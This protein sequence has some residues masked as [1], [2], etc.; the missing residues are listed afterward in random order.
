MKHFRIIWKKKNPEDK[1]GY[2]RIS[3][4]AGNKTIIRNLPLKPIEEKYFNVRKQE[5]RQS[6]KES[7]YYNAII[8]KAIKDSEKRGVKNV[9]LN[10]DK[11]SY[12][13]YLE[14]IINRQL[15]VG[16]KQKYQN[17]LNLIRK[18]NT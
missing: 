11:N 4:R 18:Y 7:E 3:S 17:H 12:I 8:D 2:L 15:V 6:F 9:R 14:K 1:K 13:E 10:D 16:T 5:V